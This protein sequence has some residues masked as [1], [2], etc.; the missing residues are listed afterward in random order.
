MKLKCTRNLLFSVLSLSIC[1]NVLAQVSDSAIEWINGRPL[2]WDLLGTVPLNMEKPFSSEHKAAFDEMRKGEY[3]WSYARAFKQFQKSPDDVLAWI[4]VESSKKQKNP[5]KLLLDVDR[6]NGADA[7]PALRLLRFRAYHLA[8]VSEQLKP[9]RNQDLQKLYEDKVD[10]RREELI[11]VQ[12]THLPT[13]VALL[14]SQRTPVLQARELV[15]NLTTRSSK[16]EISVLKVRSLIRG[17]RSY[18]TYQANDPRSKL[19]RTAVADPIEGPQL[20]KALSLLADL[21]KKHPN[22]PLIIYYKTMCYG[23]KCVFLQRSDPLYQQNKKLAVDWA[24][25]FPM[26]SSPYPGLAR[27]VE[28]YKRDGLAGVFSPMQD[29]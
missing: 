3:G 17:R 19:P 7:T 21:D 8:M 1:T 16:F 6:L 18:V 25:K 28:A 15:A 10:E 26:K 4:L 14:N 22:H 5:Q 24:G 23:Y 27:I 11:K 20:D 13:V 2:T 29:E 12:P 9:N